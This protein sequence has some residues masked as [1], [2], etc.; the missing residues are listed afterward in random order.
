MNRLRYKTLDSISVLVTLQHARGLSLTLQVAV[1]LMIPHT[2]L[3]ECSILPYDLFLTCTLYQYLETYKVL[4]IF[5]VVDKTN[6]Q[7]KS[8]Y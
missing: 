6:H 4:F 8:F 2:Q 5:P 1:V 3:N 7:D